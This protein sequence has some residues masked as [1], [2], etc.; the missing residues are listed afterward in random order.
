MSLFEPDR[1]AARTPVSMITGF[2]GSGKTTLLNRLLR[3]EGMADS[4]V[5]INEFGEIGLDH[6]LVERLDGEVAVMANGCICCTVRSDLEETLRMLLARCIE[7]G[8]R[9][10]EPGE[11]DR[12]QLDA[13]RLRAAFGV[14]ADLGDCMLQ[15]GAAFI[16]DGAVLLP[17]RKAAPA[18][19][20]KQR[21]VDVG[22]HPQVIGQHEPTRIVERHAGVAE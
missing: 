17:D 3:A 21:I 1:S 12:F 10:A 16:D 19:L 15:A 7:L 11:F 9:L 5:I 8:A 20:E 4:A 13:L 18:A 22:K 6:L 14:V 2:L